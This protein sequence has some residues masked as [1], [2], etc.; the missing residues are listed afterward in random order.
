[1]IIGDSPTIRAR[2]IARLILFV[3]LI[4]LGACFVLDVKHVTNGNIYVLCIGIV[5]YL[6]FQLYVFGVIIKKKRT[7]K[8]ATSSV[9]AS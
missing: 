6:P 5:L 7:K 8:R 4:A 9:H 1:M 3:T 2:N